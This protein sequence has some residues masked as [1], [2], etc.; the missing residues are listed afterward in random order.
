LR[1]HV[2]RIPRVAAGLDPRVV[3][4]AGN[5]GA[6]DQIAAEL[7]HDDAAARRANRMSR[8]ADSLHAARHRRRRLDLDDQIDRSHVDAELERGGRD[9]AAD[10]AGLQAILYLDALRPC[11]RAVMRAH[12]YFARQLVER[13]RQ[14]LRNAPAVD[15][16]Q[17]RS[18]AAD[19]FQK[20]R[21]NRG[22]DGGAHRPLG[23]RA[24]GNLYRL[25][26]PGHVF[27]RHLDAEIERLLR[28]RV[29][30]RDRPVLRRGSSVGAEFIVNRVVCFRDSLVPFPLSLVIS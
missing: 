20:P 30:N 3:H 27:D 1:E 22:P 25:P 23:G 12:Q 7:R 6:R 19:E 13:G 14:P 11:Q 15:K 29:D 10:R 26:D 9:E 2:E 28:R 8:T 4:R 16:N 17:R 21:M 5:R 24:A 18:M